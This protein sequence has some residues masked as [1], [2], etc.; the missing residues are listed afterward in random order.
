MFHY[1]VTVGLRVTVL[2]KGL[3]LLLCMRVCIHAVCLKR[4]L[5][6][7]W[8]GVTGGGE[9]PDVGAGVQPSSSAGSL[10]VLNC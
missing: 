2:F 6:L 9:Q 10:S 7:P 5:G 3:F 1:I 4:P 8:T